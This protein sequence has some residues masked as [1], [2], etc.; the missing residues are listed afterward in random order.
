MGALGRISGRLDVGAVNVLVEPET[1]LEVRRRFGRSGKVH[2]DVNRT[3]KLFVRDAHEVAFAEILDSRD[4][5]LH[6]GDLLLH[7]L[8]DLLDGVFRAAI[9]ED[10]GRVVLAFG[11]GHVGRFGG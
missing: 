9:I 10:E 7:L 11:L 2:V 3:G 8:D 6:R 1:F 4:F 5:A